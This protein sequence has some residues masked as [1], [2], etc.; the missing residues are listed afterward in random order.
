M[1]MSVGDVI[2][3]II[4]VVSD[5]LLV[6]SLIPIMILANS[7]WLCPLEISLTPM[8]DFDWW[9]RWRGMVRCQVS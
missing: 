5:T 8:E 6:F 4:K 7:N 9:G 1:I 3:V 2:K